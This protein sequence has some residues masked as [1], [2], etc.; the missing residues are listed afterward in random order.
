MVE[1]PRLE[2]R[3]H[4]LF[5]DIDGTLLDI[6][7]TPDTVTVD[8]V[9]RHDLATLHHL[10][11]GA[12]ALISGRSL[13]VIDQLFHRR[14]ATAGAHGAEWRFT[15][16]QSYRADILPDALRHAVVAAFADQ[17][18]I[19]LEDK[20][21]A[22]AVHYR[23]DPAVQPQ[24]LTRL[25]ALLAQHAEDLTLIDGKMVYEITYTAQHKGNALRRF[26]QEPPFR[27]RLPIFIGDDTTDLPAIAAAR[28]QGGVGIFV[29]NAAGLNPPVI[30]HWLHEECLRLGGVQG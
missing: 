11:D 1:L 22:F 20:L 9:L 5:L 6:A 27:Q 16:Q 26:M 12:L 13:A 15:P 14:M 25:T 17:P 28:E 8:P 7:P 24:V 23:Q 18:A 3:R 21:F 10:L 29:D 4:A 2:P 19:T 30:R